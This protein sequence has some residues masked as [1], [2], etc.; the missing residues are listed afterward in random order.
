MMYRV[1]GLT[2]QEMDAEEA[3]AQAIAQM[4]GYEHKDRV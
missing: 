2:P 4:H 1:R 3:D